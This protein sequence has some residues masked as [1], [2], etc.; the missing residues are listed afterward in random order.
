MLLST[1]CNERPRIVLPPAEL[2][3]CADGPR[4]PSLPVIP[5]GSALEAV[6]G[7]DAVAILK[8]VMQARDKATLDYILA[9]RSAWGDCR[10]KVNGVR[11]WS[12]RVR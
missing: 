7:A 4:A 6:T 5:W 11:A 9:G 12:Q 2:A 10:A 1:A 3:T 8:P